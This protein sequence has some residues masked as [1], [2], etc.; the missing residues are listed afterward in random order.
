MIRTEPN[1]NTAAINLTIPPAHKQALREIARANHR[2]LT[3]EPRRD[4]G[5]ALDGVVGGKVD[6]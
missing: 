6:R 4:S 1:P 5:V 3:K 2:D